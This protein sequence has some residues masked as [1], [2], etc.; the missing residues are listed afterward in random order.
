M[1]KPHLL[2]SLLYAIALFSSSAF[3]QLTAEEN[4]TVFNH[5]KNETFTI[6]VMDELFFNN[7]WY[8]SRIDE[9]E[10]DDGEENC[11]E[12]INNSIRKIDKKLKNHDR[13][14]RLS[15]K[16]F[17]E[18]ENAYVGFR[19]LKSHQSAPQN[20]KTE[21]FGWGHGGHIM[22]ALENEIKYT[23]AKEANKQPL[24]RWDRLNWKIRDFLIQKQESFEVRKAKWQ[25]VL[26]WRR[27][28]VN[29][30]KLSKQQLP[31]APNRWF[32]LCRPRSDEKKCEIDARKYQEILK[33]QMKEFGIRVDLYDLSRGN[34]AKKDEIIKLLAE[35]ETTMDLLRETIPGIETKKNK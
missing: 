22:Q 7:R 25:T 6:E 12:L 9:F 16:D 17:A 5:C 35:I 23:T 32:D 2:L 14:Q 29:A 31:T 33:A 10:S 19:I 30:Q 8:K 15:E 34:Q 3:S 18:I 4:R 27:E 24:N 1:R 28:A 20:M 13:S 21:T 11:K 26:D